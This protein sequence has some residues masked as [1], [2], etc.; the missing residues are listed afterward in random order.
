M[1]SVCIYFGGLG[2]AYKKPKGNE[3]RWHVLFPFDDCHSVKF[4]YEPQGG[5]SVFYGHL[6]NQGAQIEIRGNNVKSRTGSTPNFNKYVFDM[7]APETHSKVQLNENWDKKGVLLT[8][9]N[10]VFSVFN[11]LQSYPEANG[12]DIFL[13]EGNNTKGVPEI[14]RAHV[15]CAHI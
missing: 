12:Y 7:T 2:M 13:L 9:E 14:G 4:S 10:A 3:D 15:V 6:A 8:M 5:P 11:Y 1:A